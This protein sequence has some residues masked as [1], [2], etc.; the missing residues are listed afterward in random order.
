MI[1]RKA[2][3]INPSGCEYE[4]VFKISAPTEKLDGFSNVS[5]EL[6]GLEREPRVIVAA[7]QWLAVMLAMQYSRSILEDLKKSGWTFMWE[8]DDAR[9]MDVALNPVDM[10]Q[11]WPEIE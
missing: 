4:V 3:A 2:K 1:S 9:Y 5:L 6:Q 11:N 7:D 10:Y 8:K